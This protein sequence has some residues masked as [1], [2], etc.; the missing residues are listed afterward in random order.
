MVYFI[1]PSRFLGHLN[2]FYS[3]VAKLCTTDHQSCQEPK[4]LSVGNFFQKKTT[5]TFDQKEIERKKR[6]I[7]RMKFCCASN[8]AIKNVK[9]AR[10]KNQLFSKNIFNKIAI[11]QEKYRFLENIKYIFRFWRFFP[12]F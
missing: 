10:K 2:Y 12:S 8:A 9:I 5:I 3:I 11:F 4:T 1:Y 7:V 6:Y